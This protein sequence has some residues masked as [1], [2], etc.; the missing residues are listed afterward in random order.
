MPEAKTRPVEAPSRALKDRA[1]RV[2]VGFRRREYRCTSPRFRASDNSVGKW[3]VE[4]W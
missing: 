4:V 1:A 3:N 2:V